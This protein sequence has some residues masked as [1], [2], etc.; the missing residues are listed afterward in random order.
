MVGSYLIGGILIIF[1]I[2]CVIAFV[3]HR[4]MKLPIPSNT[5]LYDN[6]LYYLKEG[7]M[8]VF[9]MEQ[10]DRNEE[11]Y[12]NIQ[13]PN[14]RIVFV[15]RPHHYSCAVIPGLMHIISY[16]YRNQKPGE[17]L[18]VSLNKGNKCFE[19]DRSR[20]GHEPLYMVIVPNSD[21]WNEYTIS[22]LFN[23]MFKGKPWE[24]EYND[25]KEF[26]MDNYDTGNG[27]AV[28][29]MKMGDKIADKEDQ[30]LKFPYFW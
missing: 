20:S 16:T 15:H 11:F 6:N 12:L 23:N 14:I 24:Y 17:I 1:V 9:D 2:I 30:L 25:I 29:K 27:E 21:R 26:F 7:E 22:Y 10:W 5:L 18:T 3:Y 4:M 28:D 19:A 13:N 8:Y